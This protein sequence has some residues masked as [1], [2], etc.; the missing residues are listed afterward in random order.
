[1]ENKFYCILANFDEE[2]NKNFNVIKDSLREKRLNAVDIEPHITLAAYVELEEEKLCEWIENVCSKHKSFPINFNHIGLFSLNVLFLAP[3][4]SK[5]L[6]KL[7]EEIHE[8]YEDYC[9][10]IGFN[11]TVKSKNWTPHATL[12]MGQSEEVLECLP[13]VN[14]KFKP[15]V[16]QV[17]SIGIYEF[18]PM[19]EVKVFKFEK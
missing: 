11:Y 8:K 2:T 10:E 14:E 6:T 4:V 1:M 16:G 3:Q 17:T 5:E 13:I 9:G 18:Y 19:R 15:F 7:H 12:V